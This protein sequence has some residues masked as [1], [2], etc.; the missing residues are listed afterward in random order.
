MECIQMTV[1]ITHEESPAGGISVFV[2][3][4]FGERKMQDILD[5]AVFFQAIVKSGRYPLFTCGCGCFGCG[6]YY[7]DVECTDKDWILRNKYHP[8]EKSLLEN[9]EYHVSWEQVHN[10]AAQIKGYIMQL[11]Q[12]NPGTMLMSGTIGEVDLSN[13]FTEE[14]SE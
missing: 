8:L 12:K 6:G 10:V 11:I 3:V 14:N 5:V 1:N 4:Y 7:V 2:D 13:F 9:F